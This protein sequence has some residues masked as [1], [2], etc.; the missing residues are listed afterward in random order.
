MRKAGARHAKMERDELKKS[1]SDD[2]DVAR[3]SF[4]E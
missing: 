3:K 1:Y 4:M 2:V